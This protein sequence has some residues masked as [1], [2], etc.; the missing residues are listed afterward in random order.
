MDVANSPP[1]GK[2]CNNLPFLKELKDE[3]F[4]QKT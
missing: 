2:V 1:T 3:K 4:T